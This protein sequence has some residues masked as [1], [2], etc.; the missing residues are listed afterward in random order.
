MAQIAMVSA[1]IEIKSRADVFYR[2]MKGALPQL[3]KLA[4]EL[5]KEFKFLQGN[6]VRDGTV[7]WYKYAINGSTMMITDRLEVDELSKS[8]NFAVL[9]GDVL[10]EY[11][12]IKFKFQVNSGHVKATVE[13]EKASESSPNPDSYIGLFAMTINALDAYICRA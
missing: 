9:E 1:Q 10:K 8:L 2:C 7:V 5:I 13:F 4:P 11:N 12:S 6:E 3:P